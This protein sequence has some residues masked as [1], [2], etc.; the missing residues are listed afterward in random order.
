MT[1]LRV[2]E[3]GGKEGNREYGWVFLV[4]SKVEFSWLWLPFERGKY[5]WQET[6]LWIHLERGGCM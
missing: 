6:W 1:S 2:R 3:M 4:G 5:V